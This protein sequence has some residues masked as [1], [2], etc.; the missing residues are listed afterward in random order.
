MALDRVVVVGELIFLG[1]FGIAELFAL[2]RLSSSLPDFLAAA[3]EATIATSTSESVPV[4][5]RSSAKKRKGNV[6]LSYE[7]GLAALVI[8]LDGSFALRFAY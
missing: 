8:A 3:A 5:S 6:S 4:T 7:P 2:L 1:G